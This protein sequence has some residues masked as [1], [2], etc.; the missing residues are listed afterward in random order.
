MMM[1]V[2]MMMVMM[3]FTNGLLDF[4]L[5]LKIEVEFMQKAGTVGIFLQKH[6]EDI[7]S[8]NAFL[9]KLICAEICAQMGLGDFC[10]DVQRTQDGGGVYAKS[11]DKR[12]PPLQKYKKNVLTKYKL[13]IIQKCQYVKWEKIYVQKYDWGEVYA[14]S[15]DARVPPV[16]EEGEG[17]T[18]E[19]YKLI[20]LQENT[21]KS[22]KEYIWL[23]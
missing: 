18:T 9:Y 2:M 8:E 14:K 10:S 23:S 19:I 15:L 16:A 21:N 20:F 5:P 13:Q 1:M 11:R 22:N 6:T 17:C 3:K 7:S 12:N 4:C